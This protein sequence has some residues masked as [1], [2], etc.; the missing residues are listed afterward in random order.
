MKVAKSGRA[1]FLNELGSNLNQ[2]FEF[3]ATPRSVTTSNRQWFGRDELALLHVLILRS[4][5][6]DQVLPCSETKDAIALLKEAHHELAKKFAGQT[7]EGPMVAERVK[8]HTYVVT[9]AR[10]LT[11]RTLIFI[12]R[13]GGAVRYNREWPGLQS[14]E[15]MRMLIH[16][17]TSIN[18]EY[19]RQLFNLE[20]YFIRSALFMYEV[21]AQRRKA[22]RVNRE[23]PSHDDQTRIKPWRIKVEAIET[24][25]RMKTGPDGHVIVKLF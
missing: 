5:Y 14:Q 4:T 22:E 24:I 1:Y 8:G 19:G 13:S 21:R 25:E 11:R 12:R 7:I 17:L 3:V 23:R 6:L 15:V 20:L 2:T 18:R 10:D 9:G 16:R